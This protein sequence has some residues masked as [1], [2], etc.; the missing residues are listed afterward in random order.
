MRSEEYWHIIAT[1]HFHLIGN[2]LFSIPFFLDFLGFS[3]GFCK[4]W[5]KRFYFPTSTT[6]QNWECYLKQ[7]MLQTL[8]ELLLSEQCCPLQRDYLLDYQTPVH[9]NNRN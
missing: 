2:C 3:Q 4:G 1:H 8:S 6:E 7:H 5:K 9:S